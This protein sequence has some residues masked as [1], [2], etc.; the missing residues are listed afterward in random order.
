MCKQIQWSESIGNLLS[1]QLDAKEKEENFHRIYQWINK[2]IDDAIKSNYKEPHGDEDF[3][4]SP[5]KA[6]GKEELKMTL[7]KLKKARKITLFMMKP[8]SF[9]SCSSLRSESR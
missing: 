7:S 5:Q 2:D 8:L 4:Q 6:K 9:S 3:S 1:Q